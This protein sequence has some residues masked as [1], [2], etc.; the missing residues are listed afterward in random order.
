[1][2]D[3]YGFDAKDVAEISALFNLE[4]EKWANIRRLG[5]IQELNRLSQEHIAVSSWIIYENVRT[6]VIEF[7]DN[8]ALHL[9]G[10]N[11][12]ILQK[13]STNELSYVKVIKAS[14]TE[15]MVKLDLEHSKGHLVVSGTWPG[16]D[17]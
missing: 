12:F 1:M 16:L 5:L 6:L 2:A 14:M 17:I 8:S 3:A 11:P 9:A 4:I 13:L 7:A 10:V 15:N